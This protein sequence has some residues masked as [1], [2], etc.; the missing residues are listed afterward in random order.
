MSR[1]IADEGVYRTWS[2]RASQGW[3]LG[4]QFR[5]S[6]HPHPAEKS[7]PSAPGFAVEVRLSGRDSALGRQTLRV[8]VESVVKAGRAKYGFAT[9]GFN[10]GGTSYR[11]RSC[12]ARGQADG[13]YEVARQDGRIA[14]RGQRPS[15]DSVDPEEAKGPSDRIAVCL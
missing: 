14:T 12:P 15:S 5:R 8:L 9:T 13:F 4:Q 7:H 3:G 10:A 11:P 1:G 2:S 6:E